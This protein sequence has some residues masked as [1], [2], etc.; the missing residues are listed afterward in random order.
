MSPQALTAS[1]HAGSDLEWHPCCVDSQEA[2]LSAAVIHCVIA[3]VVSA[4]C[5][6]PAPPVAQS[7]TITTSVEMPV[8]ISSSGER[9]DVYSVSFQT[10]AAAKLSFPYDWDSGEANSET[11]FL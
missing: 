8:Q 7:K 5:L 10:P 3:V 9:G 1:S 6:L 2:L 4:C 11:S